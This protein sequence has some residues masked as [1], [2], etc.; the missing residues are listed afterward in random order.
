MPPRQ[1]ALTPGRR[2]AGLPPRQFSPEGRAGGHPCSAVRKVLEPADSSVLCK[3]SASTGGQASWK[4]WGPGQ[5]GDLLFLPQPGNL[6]LPRPTGVPAASECRRP[7]P[8]PSTAPHPPQLCAEAL[9]LRTTS[10]GV[11]GRRA[12][13]LTPSPSPSTGLPHLCAAG[14]P[15]SA[16]HPLSPREASPCADLPRARSDPRA[17]PASLPRTRLASDHSLGGG[18]RLP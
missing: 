7:P 17:W 6:H 1:K 14:L 13:V 8:R 11:P 5:R 12:P 4:L 2:P 16:P 10:L 15:L 18:R 9:R 3:G